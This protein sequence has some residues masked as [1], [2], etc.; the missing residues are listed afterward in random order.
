MLE[1]KT[2]KNSDITFLYELLKN[3]SSNVNIS[4][5]KLPSYKIHEKFFKSKPYS[6][7]YII[8]FNDTRVGTIY[9]SK[10]NE[11]GISLKK[12]FQGKYIDSHALKLLILKNPRSRYLANVSPKNMDSQKF[13]KKRGFKLIQYTYELIS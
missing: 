5:K 1:L 9:L 6:K 13:F 11:I 8:Y 3:R 2:S 7:W 10:Q 4:H 12:K